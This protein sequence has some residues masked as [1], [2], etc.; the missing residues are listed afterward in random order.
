MVDFRKKT[1]EFFYDAFCRAWE[2]A[3]VE[4]MQPIYKTEMDALLYELEGG[5]SY[6]QE[7]AKDYPLAQQLYIEQNGKR[8]R[9][10]KPESPY[11][12]VP[13]QGVVLFQK[14][15]ETVYQCSYRKFFQILLFYIQCL[16]EKGIFAGSVSKWE[17]KLEELKTVRFY[18]K[19]E[20]ITEK[21]KFWDTSI[22]NPYTSYA[23]AKRVDLYPKDIVS[24]HQLNCQDTLRSLTVNGVIKAKDIEVLSEY[25]GLKTL[26]LRQ[27][28]LKDIS[29][30]S[31]LVNLDELGLAGNQITDLSPLKHMKKLTHLYIADNPVSDFSVVEELP[32]LRTLYADIDQLPDQLAWD[33]IPNRI[34]LRVL[35]LT[36]LENY[37]Y[38]AETLYSRKVSCLIEKAG[39][40]KK[41]VQPSDNT[42]TLNIKDRWLYHGLMQSLGY[43]PS[44]Q[45]DLT[46]LTKLDCSDEVGMGDDYI[47]LTEVG[48]YS[49]LK[50]AIKLKTLNLSN[51]EVN[52]FSWIQNCVDIQILDLSG[53][54]FSDLSLLSKMKQLKVLR[55]SG[56]KN[57]TKEGFKSLKNMTKLK[58][59]DVSYTAF[60]DLTLLK[61]MGKLHI[62]QAKGCENLLCM[63]NMLY[64]LVNL[65][66]CSFSEKEEY[67][68]H[69][70]VLYVFCRKWT[71]KGHLL[72]RNGTGQLPRELPQ[73][74][75]DLYAM[76]KLFIT[77]IDNCISQDGNIWFLTES[78]YRMHPEIV[79]PWEEIPDTEHDVI[80]HP[81][82]CDEEDPHEA[83]P[84][85]TWTAYLPIMA[86]KKEQTVTYYALNCHDR[87][88]VFWNDCDIEY[89]QYTETTL[90]QFL[91]NIQI[92]I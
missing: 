67:L 44:V 25:T 53:T 51:R 28:N 68:F 73:L 30:L 1:D 70:S 6:I 89:M 55:L 62:L 26:Y 16:K 78:A 49:C 74:Q 11:T 19:L 61:D 5:H 76:W 86:Y 34:A 57:I 58:Q 80:Q 8:K 47:F 24:F 37:L 29:F 81:K 84:Y 54:N 43:Q 45:Y 82:C 77:Q 2:G 15:K 92:W 18:S 33:T 27:M 3:T 72:H 60:C 75:L 21:L 65:E 17:K 31:S 12:I 71:A 42:K 39:G 48:D 91:Y 63:D 41:L 23:G 9:V 22:G 32:K 13:A 10:I 52:D 69:M 79:Y 50:A 36:P 46:K 90:E 66:K 38:H 14:N 7:F 40:K 88:I 85:F 64:Q 20:K 59:L 4:Q 83:M 87:H 56:C 35:A